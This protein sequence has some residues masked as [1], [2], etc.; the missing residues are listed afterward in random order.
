MGKHPLTEL[1]EQADRVG[2][3]GG[4]IQRFGG[5]VLQLVL[6][7]AQ[8]KLGLLE[9][10]LAEIGKSRDEEGRVRFLDLLRYV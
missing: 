2:D 6:D 10:R 7:V 4:P 8:F 1:L 9:A 5:H 3:S